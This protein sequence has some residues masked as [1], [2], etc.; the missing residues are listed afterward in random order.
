MKIEPLSTPSTTTATAKKRRKKKRRKL[1]MQHNVNFEN[2]FSKNRFLFEDEQDKD[3]IKRPESR[4]SSRRNLCGPTLHCWWGIMTLEKQHPSE[5]TYHQV[6]EINAGSRWSGEDI[7]S[8]VM[9]TTKNHLVAF[10]MAPAATGA[11]PLSTEN[12]ISIKKKMLNS[13]L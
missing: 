5:Q 4:N 12:P 2:V 6:F 8:A 11:E 13:S 9:E 3:F 1:V 7:I 10:G